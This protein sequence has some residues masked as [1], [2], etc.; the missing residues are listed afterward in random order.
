MGR[1]RMELLENEK[2]KMGRKKGDSKRKD[3]K[4]KDKL[5]EVTPIEELM[6]DNEEDVKGDRSNVGELSDELDD[7]I[8]DE[9]T[10]DIISLENSLVK[11]IGR[12]RKRK[13]HDS[14]IS[15]NPELSEK[16]SKKGKGKKET[17]S[18]QDEEDHSIDNKKSR[19][20]S[21]KGE[22]PNEES[23]KVKKVLSSPVR[24]KPTAVVEPV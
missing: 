16:T 10:D 3:K 12:G 13:S 5:D 1:K 21:V 20:R 23:G 22:R 15:F 18:E 2:M 11:P 6:G 4:S 19:R 7:E 17:F 8:T 24:N 9:F 14:D